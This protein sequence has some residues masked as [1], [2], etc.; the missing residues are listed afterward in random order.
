MAARK[1]LK[2]KEKIRKKLAVND[3][4]NRKI[5]KAPGHAV[6]ATAILSK[7]ESSARLSPSV[8]RKR[9]KRKMARHFFYDM[10]G[11]FQ[12][13]RRGRKFNTKNARAE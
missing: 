4:G 7:K 10:M 13:K 1:M 8:S 3:S 5:P 9:A 6:S 12:R 2:I 11:L